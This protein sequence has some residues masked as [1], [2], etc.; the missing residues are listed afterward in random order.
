MHLAQ[1]SPSPS[2][3]RAHLSQFAPG[4]QLTDEE[5]TALEEEDRPQI[6]LLDGLP[7]LAE[8]VARTPMSYKKIK[9]EEV[10]E[11]G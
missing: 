6:D 11:I 10:F 7:Q 1:L 4:A 8:A 5:A 3:E 2:R 9:T